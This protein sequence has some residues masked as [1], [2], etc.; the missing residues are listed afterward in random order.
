[1]FIITT[2]GAVAMF[3]RGLFKERKKYI[4]ALATI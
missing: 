3:G 1:M 4:T 2:M